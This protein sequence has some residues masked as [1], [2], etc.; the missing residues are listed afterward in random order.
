MYQ[1]VE[2]YT[3]NEI[4]QQGFEV[5]GEWKDDIHD[6]RTRILINI[7][8]FKIVEAEASG[9]GVPFEICH[10]GMHK[11][12]D[13]I[14]ASIGP[15]FSRIVRS[16]IMGPDGCTHLGELML[17]SVKA[18]I[19]AASRQVPDQE[20]EALYAARWDEWMSHYSDQCIYFSQPNISREDIENAFLKAS[21]GD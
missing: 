7:Y 15:G 5:L 20:D 11:I 18:F 17:G 16:K 14:G 4:R 9:D 1:K 6:L 12:Q 8:N 19:Q 10:Q 3:V 2:K 21:R 13:I